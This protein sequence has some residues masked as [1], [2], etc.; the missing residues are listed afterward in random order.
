MKIEGNKISLHANKIEIAGRNGEPASK[1]AIKALNTLLYGKDSIKIQS[2]KQVIISSK[3]LT[4][5][6]AKTDLTISGE[7]TTIRSKAMTNIV[8]NPI[9]LIST[10]PQAAPKANAA[11]PVTTFKIDAKPEL[12]SSGMHPQA[13]TGAIQRT[14][15]DQPAEQKP[16]RPENMVLFVN[17]YRFGGVSE[18]PNSDDC[19]CETDRHH[20][21]EGLDTQFYRRLNSGTIFY[22]DGHHSIRTSNHKDML[23]FYNSARSCIDTF[24][25]NLKELTI[26][27]G[28]EDLSNFWISPGCWCK[29]VLYVSVALYIFLRYCPP[30]SYKALVIWP[31]EHVLQT[32][33]NDSKILLP[34]IAVFWRFFNSWLAIRSF[35]F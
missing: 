1:I 31:K 28:Q 15:I 2:D 12:A 14:I 8:G 10:G 22:A 11:A 4:R 7:H 33:I 3:G 29:W 9:N 30:T 27:H 5:V 18:E 16:G 19:V 34:A 20:Y 32:S 25:K 35:R 17:G 24:P 13:Q 26:K 23:S 21:W 6:I